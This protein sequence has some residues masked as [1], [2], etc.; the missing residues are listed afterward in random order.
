MELLITDRLHKGCMITGKSPRLISMRKLSAKEIAFARKNMIS[1]YY[2]PSL[3]EYESAE[4]FKEFDKFWDQVIKPFGPDHPFWRNVVSSKMQE[5][6]KSCAY[7]ALILFTLAQK[8][9]TEP[10]RIIFVCS[11]IE[12]E[13]VCEE[14]GEKMGWKVFRKPYLSL[15]SGVRRI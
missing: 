8:A 7:L 12:E 1:R 14:W 5:W 9:A 13:D 4:F 10:L 11:S 6:E 3:D 2:L 15:P